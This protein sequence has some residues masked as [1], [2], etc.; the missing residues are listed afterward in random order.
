M[1][2]FVKNERVHKTRPFQT[3]FITHY[4]L[5]KRAAYKKQV[6]QQ[7]ILNTPGTVK[8]EPVDGR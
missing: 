1:A 6:L 3:P 7:N 8:S 5:L 4:C 2:L